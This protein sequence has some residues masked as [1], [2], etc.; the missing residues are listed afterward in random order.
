MSESTIFISYSHKD[1]AW[2]DR[3]T[4][5]LKIFEQDGRVS[6]WD[7]RKIEQGHE[8]HPDIKEAMEKASVAM[9]LISADYL[10]SNF[11][12]KEETPFLLKRCDG[13]GMGRRSRTPSAVLRI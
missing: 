4:P 6:V 12:I 11:C 2:K 10:T 9:C 13:E 5:H 1:E 3:L 7:D 8:W